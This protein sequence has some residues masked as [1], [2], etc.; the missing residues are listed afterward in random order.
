[1]RQNGL[2]LFVLFIF[3]KANATQD[4]IIR[5]TGPHTVVKGHALFVRIDATAQGVWDGIY[6]TAENLPTGVSLSFPN[7]KIY[8]CKD[9]GKRWMWM[10]DS[11]T[12]VCPGATH[13]QEPG[14]FVGSSNIAF[15]TSSTTPVGTY[16]IRIKG[17]LRSDT[18][19]VSYFNYPVTVV[20]SA[21]IPPPIDYCV[22]PPVPLLK[23]WESNMIQY[24]QQHCHMGLDWYYDSEYVFYK[25]KDY[26]GTTAW[27]SCI[28]FAEI[29]YRDNY[30]LKNNGKITGFNLINANGLYEDY[31][32]T[33]DIVSKNALY[34]LADSCSFPQN[35]YGGGFT[36]MI[37]PAFFT[38]R[39]A[40]YSL[41]IFMLTEKLG[42][43][44]Y[45]MLDT[46]L[47]VCLGHCDQWFVSRPEY[48]NWRP[49]MAGVTM[50]AL[51]QYYE[52]YKQDSRI[53]HAVKNGIDYLWDN[54]WLEKDSAF[55]F[56]IAR[57]VTDCGAT[58]ADTIPAP[59]L[60]MLIGPSFGWMYKMTGDP[61][62]I[63]RG[64][65]IFAGSVK[66]AWLTGSKQ[67]NQSYRSAFDYL[68]WRDQIPSSNCLNAVSTPITDIPALEIYPNPASNTVTV[69]LPENSKTEN[70]R[71]ADLTG[72]IVDKQQ[73]SNPP[74]HLLTFSTVDMPNGIY[75]VGWGIYN[76]KLIINK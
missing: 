22:L 74:N 37:D 59:D 61:K 8:C 13:T 40:A 9:G 26:T 64:D 72:R 67:F 52:I 5:A 17:S 56:N 51:I 24:G 7:Q 30:V 47:E 70:V 45:E 65:K 60:N 3:S 46:L 2:L 31:I 19:I 75:F 32:R 63:E 35:N 16:T 10:S 49:F 53:F 28:N 68:K 4:V 39:E 29:E 42:K 25:I 57:F 27:D 15:Y 55:K 12:L 58:I 33:N 43:P 18:N 50:E 38:W 34:Y 14:Y 54:A 48:R 62:Y 41:R 11:L 6:F 73:V 36:A 1:M 66:G 21:A 44:H 69:K 20:D 71:I 76:Q 23:Q